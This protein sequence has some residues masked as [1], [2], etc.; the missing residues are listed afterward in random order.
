MLIID[1][2]ADPDKLEFSIHGIPEYTVK[3]LAV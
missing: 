2:E 1:P 3:N